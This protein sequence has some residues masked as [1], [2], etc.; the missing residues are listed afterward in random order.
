MFGGFGLCGIPENLIFALRDKGVKNLTCISNNA[1]VADFGLGLVMK[2]G[3][4]KKM[5]MS[6]GGECK[7]FEDATLS[8]KL[9]VEWTPQGTLAERIRA[10][11]A[12]IAGFYTPVGYGTPVAEGKETRVF[13][14]RWHIFERGLKADFAFIKAWKGDAMGNL[15]YR[16]TTRNF[17]Q[18]MATAAQ[19]VIAEVEQIV[20]V[21]AID[22]DAVHTPGI[23]VDMILVGPNYSKRIEKLTVRKNPHA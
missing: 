9:Q 15:A 4:I 23:Y 20:P 5:I 3:Q 14:G 22:P 18:A 11:G 19:C 8:G 12:G 7:A 1:G 2:N 17:N 16:K 10:G 6:Y 13:D 21:G